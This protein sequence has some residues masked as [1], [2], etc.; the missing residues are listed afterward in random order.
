[1]S[2][3]GAELAAGLGVTLGSFA[4]GDFY[5]FYNRIITA[6]GKQYDVSNTGNNNGSGLITGS[7]YGSAF[8]F[9]AYITCPFTGTAAGTYKV[10]QDD[11][12]DWNAGDLVAVT[13]GP[14]TN[15][16][17]IS[18]V[19]P[20]PAYGSVI[21]PLLVKVDP[22]TGSATVPNVAW[23]NYGNYNVSSA[24]GS[25]GY[26]FSCTGRITLTIHLVAT[27]YGDQGNNKL[28]LQK[29]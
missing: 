18:K 2:V 13:D 9:T 20:N 17:N 3:T 16:V 4:P 29:Q 22:A 12:T 27:V 5:T 8:T 6:S 11:W 19:W 14:G 24:A 15:F 1:M 10:I 7:N 23:G 21:S 26:V 28:I 25:S